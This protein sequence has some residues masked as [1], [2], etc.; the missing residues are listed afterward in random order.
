MAQRILVVEDEPAIAESI[1]FALNRDGFMV[2]LAQT[3]GAAKA[4][5]DDIDLIVLDLMLPDG[6]GIELL[7]ALRQSGQP[8]AVLILSS[9]SQ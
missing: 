6:D 4:K 2:T 9:K 8:T 5:L 1:E 7:Q 3:L